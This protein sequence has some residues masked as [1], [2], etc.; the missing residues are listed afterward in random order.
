MTAL[1]HYRFILPSGVKPTMSTR[2]EAHQVY[3][4]AAIIE[5]ELKEVDGRYVVSDEDLFNALAR[6]LYDD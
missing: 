4:E 6:G 1:K 2:I 5:H 3:V